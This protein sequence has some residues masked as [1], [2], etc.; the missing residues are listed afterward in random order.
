M[1]RT[2]LFALAAGVALTLMSVAG[3]RTV[4]ADTAMPAAHFAASAYG[5][6]VFAVTQE[7]DPAQAYTQQC[8]PCHGPAGKGDGP[9]AAALNP[10][11]ADMSAEDFWA[12]RTDEQL[13]AVIAEGKGAMPG[14]AAALDAGARQALIAY[15]RENFSGGTGAP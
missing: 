4:S 3:A 6:A 11:P 5:S 1:K 8:A 12:E 13:D 7:F 2:L 14:M 10:K 15:M 9:A